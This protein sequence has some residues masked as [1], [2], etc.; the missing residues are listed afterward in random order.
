MG[1]GITI[2]VFNEKIFDLLQPSFDVP[3]DRQL[4]GKDSIFRRVGTL[5]NKDPKRRALS[6]IT[7]PQ[8]HTTVSEA[9]VIS[10]SCAAEAQEAISVGVER[11]TTDQN[12]KHDQSSR[13]HAILTISVVLRTGRR[14]ITLVDLAGSER[15]ET[16]GKPLTITSPVVVRRKNQKRKGKGKR[17]GRQREVRPVRTYTSIARQQA[18]EHEADT[19]RKDKAHQTKSINQSILALESC[20]MALTQVCGVY[21]ILL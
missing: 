15:A 8:G 20:I 16:G 9:G 2:E 13:S 19:A 18:K 11:R 3:R 12:T 14:T 1:V 21:M 6:L 5:A 7:G 4:E 10:P 17:K